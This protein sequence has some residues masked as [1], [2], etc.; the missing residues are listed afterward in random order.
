MGFGFCSSVL[1]GYV[2][3]GGGGLC[4][5]GLGSDCSIFGVLSCLSRV[6]LYIFPFTFCL[7]HSK[8]FIIGG[9]GGM[10]SYLAPYFTT[11]PVS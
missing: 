11:Q 2:G 6:H 7:R 9:G 4:V 1:L 5:S 8:G 10:Y 3:Y